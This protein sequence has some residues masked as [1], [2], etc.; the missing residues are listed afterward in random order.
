MDEERKNTKRKLKEICSVEDL[1]NLLD[2][3]MLTDDERAIIWKI[4]KE[5]KPMDIVADEIGVSRPT[6]FRKHAKALHKIGK[7]FI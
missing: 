3:T 6:A 5:G 2:R 4:Y 7:M 1:K